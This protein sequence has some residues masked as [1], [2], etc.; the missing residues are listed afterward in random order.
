MTESA[1]PERFRRQG[2]MLANRVRKRFNHFR[3]R[4][5]RQNIEVFRLYDRDIPEIRAVVDWYGG[6]LVVGEYMRR[7]SVAGWLEAMA[8]AAAEALGV[9]PEKVHLKERRAGMRDGQRYERIARTGEKIVVSERDLK[10]YVNPSDFVDTGLF[11]DHRDT[12]Q[13]V[14]QAAAGRDFLNLFCYTAA[15]T[16]AAAAGGA[17]S[18]VSVDR[19][20]TA[21]AWA[22]QNLALNGFLT[23][24][25]AL[26]HAH[27][28]DY[29][30]DAKRRGLGFDL[31]VV[32]PPSYAATRSREEGF[33][34]VRD[35]RALLEAVFSV[36]RPGGEVFFSTNHQ[37]FAPDMA[38]LAVSGILE[39]TDQTIPEDYRRK[40]KKIHRCWRISI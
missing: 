30:A 12:R 29:L 26:V 11:S 32:D 6:H 7:Q 9:L 22:K 19:S 13:M 5:S 36:M 39:I 16:C 21:I 4:F 10:F 15:F 3:K 33:E 17:A 2:Q 38:G 25:N 27:A 14:R 23:D 34:V 24:R 35:H 37:R 31:A 8:G 20:E 28:Q 18:T 1:D 40:E